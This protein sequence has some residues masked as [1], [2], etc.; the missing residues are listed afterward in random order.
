MRRKYDGKQEAP[1]IFSFL[2]RNFDMG[3]EFRVRTSMQSGTNSVEI[4]NRLPRS[5]SM[6]PHRAKHAILR[7]PYRNDPSALSLHDP[8]SNH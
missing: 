5:W 1:A 6:I 3:T 4:I 2:V 7:E 8:S